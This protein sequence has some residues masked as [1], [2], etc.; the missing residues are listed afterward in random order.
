MERALLAG[1]DCCLC[2]WRAQKIHGL[3]PRAGNEPS[4]SREVRSTENG[5]ACG[6]EGPRCSLRGESSHESEKGRVASGPAEAMVPAEPC[7][8]E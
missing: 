4:L 5:C 8:P 3:Q 2:M 1:L 7:P 6:R